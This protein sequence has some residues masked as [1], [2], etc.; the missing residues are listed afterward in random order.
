M[1]RINYPPC[2]TDEN[3]LNTKIGFEVLDDD[4]MRA[5][6]FVLRDGVWSFSKTMLVRKSER[7]RYPL[8]LCLWVRYRIKDGKLRI[9]MLDDAFCQPYDYQR[10]LSNGT[11]N[12]Y[13]IG[14][15]E[16]VEAELERL[17]D[18]GIITGHVRGE[19]V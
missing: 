11:R 14:A 5:A 17:S 2:E 10:M 19:Y 3:G 6:G 7:D 16:A 8:E 15:Y 13:A 1:K 9:D 18:L 4:S 12:P